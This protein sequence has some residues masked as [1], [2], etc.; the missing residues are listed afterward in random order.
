MRRAV[1]VTVLLGFVSPD[2]Y[3]VQQGKASGFMRANERKIEGLEYSGARLRTRPYFES[4]T[5]VEVIVSDQP[6]LAHDLADDTIAQNAGHLAVVFVKDEA[7]SYVLHFGYSEIGSGRG[8][9]FD[10]IVTDAAIVGRI[11]T[12][13]VVSLFDGQDELEFDV[14]V[15]APIHSVILKEFTPADQAAA[16]KSEQMK[17]YRAFLTGEDADAIKPTLSAAMT[18]SLDELSGMVSLIRSDVDINDVVPMQVSIDGEQAILHVRTADQ[19][20]TVRFVREEGAWKIS[21]ESWQRH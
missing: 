14:Q 17:L 4:Q 3:P 8:L 13:G 16:A 19:K 21:K 10:G 11:Y 15:N 20:G 6:V 18:A 5:E 12:D 2:A 9:K 7:D 1:L